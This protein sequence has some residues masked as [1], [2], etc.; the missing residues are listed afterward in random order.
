MKKWSLNESVNE[1]ERIILV[2]KLKMNE[3]LERIKVSIITTCPSTK[4]ESV[5]TLSC[6]SLLILRPL[7]RSQ[8]HHNNT[9]DYH[10]HNH[11]ELRS[12]VCLLSSPAY[13]TFLIRCFKSW[14]DILGLESSAFCLSE[15][16]IHRGK[17]ERSTIFISLSDIKA[18]NRMTIRNI[19]VF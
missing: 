13:F 6:L 4:S 5:N 3:S 1:F 14:Q 17:N 7:K 18:A 9:P 11:R 19:S 8:Q 15:N 12:A 2:N 10:H 16:L